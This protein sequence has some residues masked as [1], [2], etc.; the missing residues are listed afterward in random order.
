VDEPET[1]RLY[2]WP[3]SARF[4]RVVPKTKF[5]EHGKVTSSLRERFVAEIHRITWAY[6]LA[7]ESI[8]LPGSRSLPEIQVFEI[9]AKGD[10]VSEHV[11]GA[12]DKAVKTPIIFEVYRHSGESG[13][14]RMVAGQR[15]AGSIPPKSGAYFTTAWHPA[16]CDRIPLPL[17]I[18]LTN[19]YVEL[20]APL[21]PVDPRAG[22][23]PGALANRV[24]AARKLER[25]IAA[26]EQRLRVEP[27]FNRKVELRRTLGTA[28]ASLAQLTSPNT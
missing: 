21:L 20:L 6:K 26:I 3:E 8:R 27:Q 18:T 7:D 22:E 9:E 13:A 11:L 10:D 17:A 15:S 5:Y 28:Q 2:R 16:A 4:G 1:A 24:D 25:D 12:I 19:L 14:V 23:D